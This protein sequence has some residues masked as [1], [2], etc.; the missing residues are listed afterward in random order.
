MSDAVEHA[1]AVIRERTGGLAPKVGI[2]LGSGL[3]TVADA[4]LDRIV[5]PYADLPGFPQPSVESHDGRLVVG[6]LGGVATAA[7]QGR[8]HYYESGR[9][10]AMKE[11]LRTL[12][13]VGCGTLI[14]TSSAG[15]LRPDVGPG[16]LMLIT[17]HINFSGTNPLIGETGDA[18][19]VDMT[20]SCDP[21]IGAR[22]RGAAERLGIELYQGVLIWFAG[23]NF[24]T[25]AEVRA[26]RILGA[27]AVG[28][29]TVPEIIL[30]RHIGLRAAAISI[31]TN[32]AAGMGDG[33]LS[34]ADSVAKARDGADKL[35]RL[36]VGFLE[37]LDD[38]E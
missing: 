37:A 16:S 5:I 11:P 24:E 10:D 22:L 1:A 17:D 2:V 19:F 27:D 29:S 36:V 34:H 4:I 25:P 31:I 18:R 20:E 32:P 14:L 13:A 38:A 9:A 35:R 7:M 15:S 8:T 6:H 26:A 12:A 21:E 33:P 30:A 28:M 3:G 23:P